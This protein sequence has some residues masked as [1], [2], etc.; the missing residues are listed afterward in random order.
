METAG[1]SRPTFDSPGSSDHTES[2]LPCAESY[3]TEEDI[4]IAGTTFASNHL[5]MSEDSAFMPRIWALLAFGSFLMVN[6]GGRFP[7]GKSDKLTTTPLID[8][9]GW[10]LLYRFFFAGR[11]NII[12]V[13]LKAIPHMS[14][15]ESRSEGKGNAA[16]PVFMVVDEV[17]AVGRITSL[18]PSNGGKDV[19]L[20]GTRFRP[21]P[22]TTASQRCLD[23]TRFNTASPSQSPDQQSSNSHSYFSAL[24]LSTTTTRKEIAQRRTLKSPIHTKKRR[25]NESPSHSRI[26]HTT[27][28]TTTTNTIDTLYLTLHMDQVEMPQPIGDIDFGVWLIDDMCGNDNE[29]RFSEPEA[30]AFDF[31]PSDDNDV[32]HNMPENTANVAY[33]ARLDI[34]RFIPGTEMYPSDDFDGMVQEEA[35]LNVVADSTAGIFQISRE[36]NSIQQ[37]PYIFHDNTWDWEFPIQSDNILSHPVSPTYTDS[38]YNSQQTFTPQSCDSPLYEGIFQ[39]S[40]NTPSP[41]FLDLGNMLLS[42]SPQ[43]PSPASDI[44]LAPPENWVPPSPL[45]PDNSTPASPGLQTPPTPLTPGP[46][47]PSPA[48]SSNNR[49]GRGSISK[50]AK[51]RRRPSN[52]SG[53]VKPLRC[54]FP[55]DTDSSPCNKE[56]DRKCDLKKHA[57]RHVKP[58]P[59]RFEGCKNIRGFSSEKDR[60][61]HENCLHK[62]DKSKARWGGGG[63]IEVLYNLFSN[64]FSERI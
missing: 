53:V 16:A 34:N 47:P 58:F 27:L 8:A 51:R 37:Q 63:G 55:G 40:P 26:A 49:N 3:H 30:A 29:T 24:P 20:S 2:K 21:P 38:S 52:P 14:L 33:D 35:N 5:E 59:C 11:G 22:G 25:N 61:R 50:P 44:V 43:T 42:Q 7:T 19:I 45:N 13:T 32:P 4:Y 36:N 1:H 39:P 31:S 28:N 41:D 64:Y 18:P 57:K 54:D 48:I 10:T 62:K 12:T 46:S 56:F 23:P 15:G 17:L 6:I 9:V 60:E